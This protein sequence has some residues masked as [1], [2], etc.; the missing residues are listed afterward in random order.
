MK[1][2][3]CPACN[4]NESQNI[5]AG[6]LLYGKIVKCKKCGLHYIW[7]RTSADGNRELY[8]KQYYDSWA[9]NELGQDG[10]AKIKKAT[11]KQII[12]ILDTYNVKKGVL[13]DIGCAFG[14]LL[15]CAKEKGWDVHGV[16]I[17]GYA[18]K[19]AMEK[20]GIGKIWVGNFMDF[21]PPEYKY[22]VITMIDIIEHI[23]DINGVLKKCQ[24]LLKDSGILVIVTPDV[25]SV[26]RI[27][28]KGRWPHFKHEH[29]IYLSFK[30]LKKILHVH[31][32]EILQVSSFKKAINFHYL[33]S[34]LSKHCKGLIVFLIKIVNILLP[35]PIKQASF[36]ISTGE[37]IV[38]AQKNK[39]L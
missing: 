14:H 3:L 2:P 13:L 37:M 20:I 8:A 11:F 27:L 12:D 39:A 25:N 24:E 23:Y 26:S 35:E 1:K 33:K 21:K 10:V 30:S 7:P 34:Q 38:I 18:A 15:I 22:D 29:V 17:C 5:H 19:K 16:E 28:L 31:N 4:N 36:F 6:G 32:M 9:F